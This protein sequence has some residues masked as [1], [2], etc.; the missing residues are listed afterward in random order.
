MLSSIN[1]CKFYESEFTL[2]VFS[3]TNPTIGG[4]DGSVVLQ[5]VGGR[6]TYLYSKDLKN[7][8]GSN[9]FTNLPKGLYSF[10]A[11]DKFNKLAFVTVKLVDNVNCGDYEDNT[12]AQVIS[13]DIQLEN[14]L[15][16]TLNDFIL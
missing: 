11:L 1:P 13:A 15:N 6:A 10:Y 3:Q 5:A 16:C 4:S 7:W 2:N 14:V 12:L 9:T 8:Y